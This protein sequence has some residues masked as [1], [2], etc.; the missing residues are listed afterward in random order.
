MRSRTRTGARSAYVTLARQLGDC[1]VSLA[2]TEGGALARASTRRLLR[3]TRNDRRGALA[4]TSTRRL[5][6][7]TRN[8]RRGALARTST[9]RLLRFTRNDRRRGHCFSRQL[10]DCFVSLAM[11]EGGGTV[12]RVNSAIASFHLLMGCDRL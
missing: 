3:F 10:G 11:T 1:F 5:L 12:S 8:D 2:M 4:R 6:R 9:R 7:F